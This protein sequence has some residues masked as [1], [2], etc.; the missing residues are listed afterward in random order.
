MAHSVSSG[1]SSPVRFVLPVLLGAACVPLGALLH[2]ETAEARGKKAPQG[3]ARVRS[4]GTTAGAEIP[5]LGV[6]RARIEASSPADLPGLAES[7][8]ANSRRQDRALWAP[9]L[10]KWSEADGA[11][12]I[13]FLEGK[14]PPAIRG[15]LL[16]DAWFAWGA[17]DP[18][19]AISASSKLA[20][21]LIKKLLAG[22]VETDARKAADFALN[23]PDAQFA[24]GGI[25]DK[26]AE[27]EPGLVEG[28]LKRS[29]YDGSRE[30]F[31]RARAFALAETDPAAAIEYSR[32]CGIIGNDPVPDVIS[33]IASLD[34]KKAAEQVAAMPSSR[35]KALS[36]V[37][38]AG[39]W[40]AKDSA[41]AVE[42]IHG[43]LEGPVK[44]DALIAAA[45]AGRGD[46]R[47]SLELLEEAGREAGGGFHAI[48]DNG[49][50]SPS[51]SGN[52]PDTRKTAIDL[53]RRWADQD[54]G[55]AR[56]YAR[57]HLSGDLLTAAGLA[58]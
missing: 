39:D 22:V 25:A 28:L 15:K 4:D 26:I 6:W 51:E 8:M 10:A 3:P 24:L 34:P 32:K 45:S 12:M 16:E 11:A 48:R 43:T 55:A 40:A 56:D 5:S 57:E 46:P 23:V 14:A 7:L 30:P 19:A 50:V 36:A 38:L 18:D 42:W 2:R 17:S 47:A 54:A 29:V 58:P 31:E 49:T 13:A 20:P 9:L 33:K 52:A 27:K 1:T 53:L 21:D 37:Q 35:T 41:A 44:R